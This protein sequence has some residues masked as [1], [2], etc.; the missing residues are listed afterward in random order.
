MLCI[1]ALQILSRISFVT[2]KI[3]AAD[4]AVESSEDV[5]AETRSSNVRMAAHVERKRQVAKI[6]LREQLQLHMPDEVLSS[7]MRSP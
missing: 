1:Y 7:A 4:V 6:R 5:H 2:A 3:R